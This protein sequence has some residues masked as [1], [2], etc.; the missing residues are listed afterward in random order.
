[1]SAFLQ[2]VQ[3]VL[4]FKGCENPQFAAENGLGRVGLSAYLLGLIGGYHACLVVNEVAE[5]LWGVQDTGP[6]L[7]VHR[8]RPF[9]ASR[10]PGSPHKISSSSSVGTYT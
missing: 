1:M 4:D 10:L 2:R 3:N 6:S 8:K 7:Q 5:I 9:L